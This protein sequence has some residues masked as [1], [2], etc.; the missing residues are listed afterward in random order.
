MQSSRHAIFFVQAGRGSNA[1]FVL[2]F[3]VQPT[4]TVL[5]FD[6]ALKDWSLQSANLIVIPS[7]AQE[8]TGSSTTPRTSSSIR[9]E[10]VLNL[11]ALL[12]K[13]YKY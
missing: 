2:G 7:T 4:N 12:L 11:L 1:S 13:K 6:L 8:T 9:R 10:E 3:T 5:Q